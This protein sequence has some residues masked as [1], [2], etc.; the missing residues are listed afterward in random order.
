MNDT[1]RNINKYDM[2]SI[3]LTAFLMIGRYPDKYEYCHQCK[4]KG[5]SVY[6]SKFTDGN[7]GKLEKCTMCNGL[8]YRE[9]Q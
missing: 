1:K 7:D 9:K 3:K 6:L 8:G 2:L 5:K 4:G